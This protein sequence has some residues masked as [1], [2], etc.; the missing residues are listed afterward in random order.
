MEYFTNLYCL[1]FIVLNKQFEQK[2]F[3]IEALNK[4]RDKVLPCLFNIFMK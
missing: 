3:D 4:K 2:D 1:A